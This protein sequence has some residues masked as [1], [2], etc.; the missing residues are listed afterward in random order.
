M[1]QD[2]LLQKIAAFDPFQVYFEKH[3]HD[4]M[5]PFNVH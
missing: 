5:V 3:A 2:Q 1:K 4:G